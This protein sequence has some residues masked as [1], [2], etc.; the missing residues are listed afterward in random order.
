[1]AKC[2]NSSVPLHS[3][4]ADSSELPLALIA[5]RSE[6]YPHSERGAGRPILLAPA[7]RIARSPFSKNAVAILSLAFD[8]SFTATI[9][10]E[11]KV[12][13][14]KML[15]RRAFAQ[16]WVSHQASPG[17][18]LWEL[19]RAVHLQHDS[20]VT[21]VPAFARQPGARVQMMAAAS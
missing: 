9:E 4:V 11:E 20:C 8:T 7:C 19:S 18:S 21:A 16:N 3:A 2:V 1:M 13:D 12:T 5:D 6:A 14:G 10:F 15:S 17:S